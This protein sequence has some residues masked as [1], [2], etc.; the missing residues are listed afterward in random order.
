LYNEDNT[1]NS[2]D[3]VKDF[4]L[5]GTT[6]AA[7]GARIMVW[8]SLDS[9][10]PI[11]SSYTVTAADATEI[12]TEQT[13]EA[14]TE[15]VTEQ[16]TEQTTETVTEEPNNTE[17]PTETA[18]ANPDDKTE[19]TVS[20]GT[21]TGGADGDVMLVDLNATVPPTDAPAPTDTPAPTKDP[22]ATEAPGTVTWVAAESGSAYYNVEDPDP[23][24]V[25]SLTVDLLNNATTAGNVWVSGKFVIDGDVLTGQGNPKDADA[26]SPE[27]NNTAPA[28]GTAAKLT[29]AESGTVD[30]AALVNSGKVM[31]IYSF[32]AGAVTGGTLITSNAPEAKDVYT[33]TFNVEPG[34]DYYV[35]VGGSKMGISSIKF[36]P[37]AV[38][39]GVAS[40]E[41]SDSEILVRSLK[42]QAGDTITVKAEEKALHDLTITTAPEVTV[43]ALGGGYYT[44]TMPEADTTVNAEYVENASKLPDDQAWTS[45]D[46]E[47]MA[48]ATA[49]TDGVAFGPVNGLSGYGGWTNQA[50][51]ATYTHTN[52]V[53][54]NFTSAFR[55][56]SG[57]ATK[58]SFYFT[59]Q[60]ACIVTVAYTAQA[61]RP[62]YIYQ[63][64]TLLASGEE[65]AVNGVA[66]TISADVENPAAGDVII[67]GGS[68]NK[69]IYGIFADYY[70]PTVVT[71]RN[72][73]GNINYS[74]AADTSVLQLVFKDTNDGTEYRADFGST[75]SVD[76]RQNRKYD[77]YVEENGE[78]SGSVSTTLDTNSVSIAKL[79]KTFDIDVVDIAPTEVTGDVVV[80]DVYNDGTSLDLS[81]VT[82][83]F[84]ADDDASLTY[85]T[86]ITD[87]KIAVTM[88]P[89]HNYTVTA[90]GNDGYALSALS[91]SYLMAAGDTA[92][93]K[94]ILFTEEVA[95]ADFK[96]TVEVGA[97]KEFSRINDAVKV[98]KAMT[99]RPAGEEGRVTI[100]V[101]PGVYTEQVILDSSYITVKAANEDNKP[102][103]Q[104]Y[105]G[106]G[107]LY[108]SSAGNQYYSEDYAVAKTKKGPVTRWGAACRITGSYV[109]LESITIRHTFNC[110]VS[111]AELADGVTPAEAGWYGD[112]SGKPD[113]TVAGYDAMSRNAVERAA[114]IALDGQNAELY[115]CEFIS[116]QDT[117]Y[118]NNTAYVKDCYIEG[119]TDYIYG[120]NSVVFEGCTLAWHGYSDQAT[121]GYITANKNAADPVPGTPNLAAN[122]YLLK[123]CTVTNSKYYTD[124]Q[125]AAGSWG[126]NWGGVQ[127]HV[128][129]D[130]I[131]L[132]GVGVPG[133]WVKMGGELSDSILYVND[134]TDKDGN[135]VDVS[136]TTF[137]PNGT[138]A[139]NGYTVMDPTDY[140]GT[141]I[142]TH[143]ESESTTE[144]D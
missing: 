68:S 9:M 59:P 3:V 4:E 85:T 23:F 11:Y 75:Y 33:Y 128:V 30:F 84:T 78:K 121:G 8:D 113:R 99:D 32:D 119:G 77:I 70:D 130:G 106:I 131:T 79:D 142:P 48:A 16:A 55:A 138:M 6:A 80:H 43:T 65:G 12:P 38:S 129:F 101:D 53:T 22:S 104:W 91:G 26:A 108:Y 61:G 120:G 64:G 118:T 36:A 29:A 87:N 58:R 97:D 63:G 34:K 10:K 18:T 47:L 93:F 134:V 86:G 31:Y 49:T 71:Y 123:N 51:T 52:G 15:Q 81:D 1:L 103:I 24:T 50:S 40:V 89:N 60:Q 42:A 122:G 62:V 135:E 37:A 76:L 94:N 117:F 143:Y 110:F 57:S 96:T 54:Y 132:D 2:I 74:G 20:I 102:E 98:I 73:S 69:D 88:M 27:K 124:N 111:E 19:Y 44:F 127:T 114:A 17:N 7:P 41:A 14:V 28:T 90:S 25:G 56:G 100:L 13:T 116:S 144:A 105:Y 141:W 140:F 72:L 21:I 109:Q 136:G 95:A 66:A 125:F 92:P 5:G 82:L 45:L 46:A 115:N 107:Y 126:R 35:F 83:T 67:Y 112:V 137:N 39:L 139:A 133:A